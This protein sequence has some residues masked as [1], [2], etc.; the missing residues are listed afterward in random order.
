MAEIKID[1]FLGDEGEHA[2]L[3][4]SEPPLLGGEIDAVDPFAA[5]IAH[6]AA[7]YSP[8]VAREVAN[9][10]QVQAQHVE[11]QSKHVQTQTTLLHDEH[12]LR[13]TH[14]RNQISEETVR[15][16]G[17]RLRVGF[18]IFLACVATAIGVFVAF[19]LHD[20][21]LSRSV[22]IDAFEIAP[23]L[24]TQ[25]P[26]GKI[27]ANGLLDN[28][29]RIQAATRTS[30]LRR[31][32][33]NAWTNDIA[34]EVPETGMSI[35]QLEQ[36]LKVRF[37]HDQRI[38]GDVMLAE[39]G[40]FALTVR[41]TGILAKTF[42]DESRNLDKLL[43][44]A[45]EYI[46]GQSQPGLWT[47]YLTNAGRND[48]AIQF[49]QASYG[50]VEA[51]ERPYVLNSWGNAI[52]GKGGINGM[53]DALQLYR[54]TVRLKPDYWGG[55]NNIIYALWIMGQEEAAVREGELMIKMAG[56]R[57]GRAQ[58]TMYQNYDQLLWDLSAVR[59][60]AIA[61][62][63][64]NDGVG[65]FASLAGSANL[66]V[67]QTE[68]LL[69]DVES[70]QLRIKTTPIDQNN[71][72]DVAI[73]ALAKALLAEENGD[74]QQAALQWDEFSK[75]YTHPE[76]ST[77][78]SFLMCYAA[79]VY[80]KVGQSNKADAALTGPLRAVGIETFTDC[81]RFKGD[82][83]DLRNDWTGAQA[84]YAQAIKLAPSIPSGYYSYGM[85]LLKHGDL[86]HA[87]EQLQLA[88]QKGPN[89]ADPLKAWGDVLLKQ[90]KK[91]EALEK[92]QEALKLAPKWTQLRQA[93]N[94][95]AKA[96]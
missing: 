14:L 38:T 5:T 29:S 20:A 13:L 31:S 27:V 39:N 88:N 81:L 49:A 47:N 71:A 26:S 40:A 35:G 69:H 86:S 79:P 15:R 21:V 92:Y 61:D 52:A 11:V 66:Q 50:K 30:A 18:Q 32:L 48:D 96:S 58:E 9:F 60:E 62:M 43:T 53:K 74:L 95:V 1:E 45:S 8:E 54:E 6:Q 19:M 24:A 16:L 84:A 70:A 68:T 23:N 90:G 36:A 59:S 37:G 80:E 87:A 55:Y 4:G 12:H 17:I 82:V 3:E 51:S 34:I 67:A 77:S 22:V 28:L 93:Q 94:A 10:L 2:E 65:I 78:N 91:G 56:G 85:A 72:A 57:P 46:Y 42:T 25:V 73:G 41:G 83:L 76:V 89:W 7:I 63:E 33:S 64:S 44:Q 75:Q